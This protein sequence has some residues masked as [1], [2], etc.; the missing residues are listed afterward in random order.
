MRKL[1]VAVIGAGNMGR[2]HLRNYFLLPEAE[3]LGLADI[4]PSTKSLAEEFRV[5]HFVDYKQML[6]TVKPDAV[7]IVVPTPLHYEIASEVMNRGIHCLLEKPITSTVSEA[8]K[9]IKLA[10][11][12]KIVFTVGHIEQY[13]PII[14]KIRELVD[15]KKIGKI[16][17]ISCRRVGGFPAVEPKTDV[18][19]DLAVHDID[20]ISMLLKKQ[21]TQISSHGSRT[22]HSKKIDSAEILLD[23]GDASGFVQ[24]NWLTPV[25]IRTISITGSGG[26][27]EGNYITQELELYKHNME[28]SKNGDFSDFVVRMGDPEKEVIKVDF[29]EPLAVELKAFLAKIQGEEVHLVDPYSARE[30]L[31]IALEAVHPYEVI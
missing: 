11:A 18:I 2:N 23:Y 16:T 20:L 26:Y 29:Q 30:A 5:E 27:L 1:K 22:H 8:D 14:V 10:K 31:R 15:S 13:N 7:S 9:L 6:N 4:N 25:K 17:S 24:A 21:P 19:I 12:K 28:K 3:L